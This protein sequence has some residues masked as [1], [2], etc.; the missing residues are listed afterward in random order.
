[1]VALLTA[2]S[3][4]H[5]DV[6]GR[7]REIADAA[8]ALCEQMLRLVDEDSAAFDRVSAAYR[9]PK[10]DDAQK[11]QRSA[12]IQAALAGAIDPP[13]RVIR[14][15]RSICD[16]AVELADIGNP[17]AH[18]D[19]GC[20]ALCAQAAARGAALN[21]DVNARSLRDR[22]T[23]RAHVE[24]AS[25]EVAQVDVLCEVILSTLRAKAQAET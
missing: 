25:S 13:S 2:Q 4:K 6:A 20:A 24:R 11:T 17:N 23:G 10:N 15:A 21:V 9:M 8:G 3:P 1:M 22:G 12:A 16:L 5:A 14:L 19:I 7:C 18:S